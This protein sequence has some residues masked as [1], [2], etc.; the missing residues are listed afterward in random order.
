MAGREH[1]C[2]ERE[3]RE[4]SRKNHIPPLLPRLNSE[5]LGTWDSG[6]NALGRAFQGGNPFPVF[7][8]G[9]KMGQGGY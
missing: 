1:V 4:V 3:G 2:V 9:N 5:S 8:C 7:F 6:K